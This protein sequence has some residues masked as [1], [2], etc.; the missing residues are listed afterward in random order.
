MVSQLANIEWHDATLMT[1]EFLGA[2]FS[3]S[4]KTFTDFHVLTFKTNGK[5]Q[6]DFSDNWG[7]SVQ[8]YSMNLEQNILKLQVQSGMMMTVS[9][10]T[11]VRCKSQKIKFSYFN[12]LA[13]S[14]S[15]IGTPSRI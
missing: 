9:A 8:I 14:A 12:S 1:V 15:I 7:P 10:C 6:M 4:I 5:V 13:S 11:L 2:T 3:I